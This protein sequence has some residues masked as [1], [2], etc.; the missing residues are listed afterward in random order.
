MAEGEEES[1]KLVS[2]EE[3][4]EEPTEANSDDEVDTD[5]PPAP[6]QRGNMFVSDYSCHVTK[7]STTKPSYNN[8][9][10]PSME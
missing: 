8:I 6:D 10:M 3:E 2:A 5:K 7:V 9:I 1:V 4:D